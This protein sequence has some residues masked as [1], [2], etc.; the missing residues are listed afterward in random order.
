MT[1]DDRWP[2]YDILRSRHR[3]VALRL[4]TCALTAGCF[5]SLLGWTPAT[6]WF[7]LYAILQSIEHV[8]FT[9]RWPFLATPGRAGKAFLLALLAANSIVFGGISLLEVARMGGWG[10]ACAAFLLV[11]ALTSTAL[12][13]IGCP[14]A[15]YAGMIPLMAYVGLLPIA[16][17]YCSD[18]LSTPLLVGMTIGGATV[19]TGNLRLWRD[20]TTTKAAEKAAVD[21]QL[22]ERLANEERLSRLA[23]LDPLTEIANR[24]V[25][26]ARLSN[27][28][29]VAAPGSLLLI[30]L[31]G[32]KNVN[33]TLGHAAGDGVLREVAARLVGSVGP[34]DLVARMGG[35]E[36]AVLL[37]DVDD[38][39]AAVATADR[40]V[41]A[42]S[43]TMQIDDQPVT[44]GASVG[45]AINR[46]HGAGADE[47]LAN[48]DLALYRAKAAGRHCSRLYQPAWHEPRR[49][50]RRP[51]TCLT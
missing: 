25:L 49:T 21:R 17:F 5:G 38:P 51:T 33:D 35:D 22:S 2:L 36:F 27:I 15:L 30:D 9:G 1:D 20:L 19:V 3:Q 26:R 11:G 48:A 29:A 37:P 39:V 12:G 42:L 10:G 18:H 16:A 6:V 41:D 34:G 4:A 43:Q 28:T 44:I 13:T 14:A 47:L 8:C 46:R 31:D 24:T 23:H 45:I 50:V 32:F 40:I 7:G